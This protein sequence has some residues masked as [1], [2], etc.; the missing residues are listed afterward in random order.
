MTVAFYRIYELDSAEQVMDGYS[1]VCRSDSAALAMASNCAENRAA[2][3]E[4]WEN[5]RRVARLDCTMTPRTTLAG[6]LAVVAHKACAQ[7]GERLNQLRTGRRR[8]ET[9]VGS[10]DG[11]RR[12]LG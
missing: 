10:E 1:V 3:V 12:D 7:F 4:V 6:S 8:A 5:G 11:V 2:A 9:R